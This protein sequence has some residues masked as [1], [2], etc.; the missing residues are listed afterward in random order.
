MIISEHEEGSVYF[1]ESEEESQYV[2]D[3]ALTDTLANGKSTS[4]QK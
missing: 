1:E 4:K 2:T 3:E